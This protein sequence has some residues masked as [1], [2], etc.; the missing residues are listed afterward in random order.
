MMQP[1]RVRKQPPNIRAMV[2]R[3]HRQQ[4][5][6]AAGSDCMALH[7]MAYCAAVFLSV[8]N[9]DRYL[10]SGR[11][12]GDNNEGARVEK[13]PVFRLSCLLMSYFA[14][15]PLAGCLFQLADRAFFYAPPSSLSSAVNDLQL[16]LLINRFWLLE[17]PVDAQVLR[18]DRCSN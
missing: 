1:E 7:S 12:P 6:M 14:A 15:A 11:A 2:E 9:E 18:M 17:P 16:P 3:G 5:P 10:W 13:R 8:N 4:R